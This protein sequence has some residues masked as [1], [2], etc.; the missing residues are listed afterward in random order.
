MLGRYRLDSLIGRGASSIVYRAHDTV[1][2]QDVAVKVLRRDGIL[3]QEQASAIALSLRNETRLAMLLAH[4]NVLRVHHYERSGDTEYLVMELAIGENLHQLV[5]RRDRRHLSTREAVVYGLAV[6]YALEHAHGHGVIHNDLKP[7]NILLC[8]PGGIKV[9]DFGLAQLNGVGTASTTVAG[10]PAFMSPERIRGEPGDARSDLY[11]MAATF[12]TL[13][14]GRTPFGERKE[15]IR[16]HLEAPLPVSSLLPRPLRDV[17]AKA[18]AK[19]PADRYQSARAMVRAWEGMAEELSISAPLTEGGGT[20]AID[21]DGL[22]TDPSVDLPPRTPWVGP[23]DE[24]SSLVRSVAAPR[25][26]GSASAAPGCEQ[27]TW[28][29]EADLLEI[30]GGTIPG[31]AGPVTVSRFRLERT[32]VTNEDF[33]R[34]VAATGAAPPA[35]WRG[36]GVPRGRE[37]H[38]VAGVT[39]HQARAYAA[40]RGRRLPTDA[41]WVLG[42]AGDTG[43]RFPWGDDWR[44]EACVGLHN[45]CGAT[46]SV[47]HRVGSSPEG[48][49]DLLGNVWEWT[50]HDPR[51]EAPDVGKAWVWGASFRQRC[52]GT[53]PSSP[54][55]TGPPRM[56]VHCDDSHGDLGFRCADDG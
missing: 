35:D 34:Y 17:L 21:T 38:P 5:R 49:R 50:E 36:T 41:E 28:G 39:L 24:P 26:A 18:M 55:W 53:G 45:G 2:G 20:R 11:S 6:L 19:R 25:E 56:A 22:P 3:S 40:W 14:A 51:L 37:Q 42:Y 1:L 54:L 46:E 12:F 15:A 30:G 47:G 31:P 44:P 23:R 10:T 52:D 48:C 43:R 8:R 27:M 4:P 33:G 7:A 9:C 13:A 29:E 32:P 16:G